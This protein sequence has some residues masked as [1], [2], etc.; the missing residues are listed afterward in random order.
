MRLSETEKGQAWLRQ[1]KSDD[2][3][4]ATRLLDQMVLVSTS[5][6]RRWTAGEII[7]EAAKGRLALYGARAVNSYSPIAR[8]TFTFP[9][10]H[11]SDCPTVANTKAVR[12]CSL[13]IVGSALAHAVVV[14]ATSSVAKLLPRFIAL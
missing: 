1:F 7:R 5:D 14:M 11:H 2:I 4:A 9:A 6:Y 13:T 3:A 10:G 12:G 8:S